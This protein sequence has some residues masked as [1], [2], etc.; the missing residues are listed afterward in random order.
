MGIL[1]LRRFWAK[2]AKSPGCWQ[3]AGAKTPKGYGQI[4]GD[5][6]KKLRYAHRVSYEIVKGAI[7][8]GLQIDHLCR[9]PSCVNPAH[10][11]A[12]TPRENTMRGNAPTAKKARQTH[13]KRGHP[14]SGDNLRPS[15]LKRGHRK[16]RV[17]YRE[18]QRR[19]REN[20]RAGRE[21]LRERFPK[22]PST[23][24]LDR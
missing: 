17:C 3:W 6:T 19:Y 16:C 10:L 7:P 4:K 5:G 20:L 2:V 23:R 11:E 15:D 9:N 8:D 21:A 18:R 14:L 12:V 22:Q 1:F 13:C 24:S